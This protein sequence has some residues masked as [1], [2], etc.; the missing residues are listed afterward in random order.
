MPQKATP[1][2]AA[3][4]ADAPKPKAQKAEAPKPASRTLMY[5]AAAIIILAVA[6]AYTVLVLLP[7]GSSPATFSTFKANLNA[8]SRVAILSTYADPTQL[9]IE[10]QCFTDIVQILSTQRSPT[11]ID[12]YEVNATSCTYSPNGLGHEV[13]P[14]N[15]TP[16][17]CLKDA[18]A[19]PSIYLNYST[20]NS[21]IITADHMYVY[22]DAQYFEQCPVAVDLS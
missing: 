15:T 5:V 18:A 20:S 11:T 13:T 10:S 7:S 1:K 4:K 6:A 2:G 22:G 19:E 8:A 9:N 12:F 16:A 21:S 3:N 14:A 17:V